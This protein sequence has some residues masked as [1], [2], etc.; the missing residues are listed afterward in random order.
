MTARRSTARTARL[1]HVHRAI[2]A[3]AHDRPF[4]GAV[5]F[6]YGANRKAHGNLTRVDVCTCGAERETNI[7]Q[8]H[9][10]VG[11]WQLRRAACPS[12]TD[13]GVCTPFSTARPIC[14]W[15]YRDLD[16]PEED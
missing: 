2:P 15:C 4:S 16:D 12:R 7:N 10:E 6:G 1:T 8:Q 9:T 14:E 11:V 3:K 13:G 5:A